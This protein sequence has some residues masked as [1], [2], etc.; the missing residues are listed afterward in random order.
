MKAFALAS[1]LFL[2]MLVLILVNVLYINNVE[3][4]LEAL[5]SSLPDFHSDDCPD[6]ARTLV[7]FWERHRPLVGLSTR[8][9]LTDRVS[10]HAATLLACAEC[11]D[12]FGYR[13]ALA[14]LFDAVDDISRTEQLSSV[15]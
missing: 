8:Y 11:G 4:E 2:L 1:M 3:T 15:W 10:E 7:N 6:A 9:S 14:L 12:L 13:T 5:L